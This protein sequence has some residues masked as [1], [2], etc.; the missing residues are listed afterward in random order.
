DRYYVV[1]TDADRLI[2]YAGLATG[3]EATVMTIGVAPAAAGKATVRR[4]SPRCWTRRA[5]MRRNRCAWKCA[6]RTT[7][8][9]GSIAGS[10]SSRWEYDRATINPRVPTHWSC[11]CP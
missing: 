10:D 2:G 7:A 6:R 3:P 11:N 8:P 9:S 1:L 5:G 4:C